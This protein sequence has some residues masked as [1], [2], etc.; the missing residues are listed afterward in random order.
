M[1]NISKQLRKSKTLVYFLDSSHQEIPAFVAFRY[2]CLPNVQRASPGM[3]E[4][5]MQ[6]T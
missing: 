6:L 3:P 4:G 1:V 5:M 2:T